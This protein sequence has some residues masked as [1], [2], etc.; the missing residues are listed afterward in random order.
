MTWCQWRNVIKYVI[1]LPLKTTSKWLSSAKTL[2]CIP[3]SR[4]GWGM[5]LF[6]NYINHKRPPKYLHITAYSFREFLHSFWPVWKTSASLAHEGILKCVLWKRVPA[7]GICG[8]WLEHDSDEISMSLYN[9]GNAPIRHSDSKGQCANI[10][11]RN[12]GGKEWIKK[13]W[14]VMTRC[15]SYQKWLILL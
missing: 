7:L 12:L 6:C 8:R 1:Y 14:I 5:F 15:L 9:Q 11:T 10:H 2:I 3:L 13:K 4:T